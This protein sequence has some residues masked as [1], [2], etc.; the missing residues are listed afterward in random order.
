M[1]PTGKENNNLSTLNAGSIISSKMNSL[2]QWFY[3]EK[4]EN[5]MFIECE[6]D[7]SEQER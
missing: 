4:D 2:N 7:K 1:K 5:Q 3:P 6:E